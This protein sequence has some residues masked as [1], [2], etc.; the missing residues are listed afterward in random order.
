MAWLICVCMIGVLR[1]SQQHFSHVMT[2]ACCMKHDS[3]RVLSAANP[4]PCRR[5]KTRMHHPVP[6]SWHWANQSWIYHLNTEHLARKQTVPNFNAFGLARPGP[7]P[8]PPDYE[9]NDLSTRPHSRLG[10][11]ISHL[12]RDFWGILHMCSETFS[13]IMQRYLFVAMRF[14]CPSVYSATNNVIPFWKHVTQYTI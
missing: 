5:R 11:F 8:Q 3:A 2:A 1:H 7:N 4:V 14:D 12:M 13:V 9:A 6:I 10:W